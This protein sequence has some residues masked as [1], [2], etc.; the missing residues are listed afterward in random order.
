MNYLVR[1]LSKSDLP[2]VSYV[3]RSAFSESALAQ[4]GAGAISRYYQWQMEGPHDAVCLGVFQG[5]KLLGFCVAGIFRGAL[6]GFVRKNRFYLAGLVLARPWLLFSPLFLGRLKLGVS[7]AGIRPPD[8]PFISSTSGQR[9]FG[10]LS[11]AVSPDAQGCGVGRLLMTEV[12]SV[13]RAQNYSSLHLSV[14]AR[15][16]AAISFYE[17]LGFQ[18][19]VIPE[20]VWQGSMR[21]ILE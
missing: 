12:E 9:S 14:A 1:G 7:V 19:V 11:I 8:T 10:I 13:A 15:N 21:K 3:H 17:N 16:L 2:A 6:S 5:E 4:L 18:R 20:G